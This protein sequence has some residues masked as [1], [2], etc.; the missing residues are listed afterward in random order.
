MRKLCLC[1]LVIALFSLSAAGQTNCP[2]PTVPSI[3]SSAIPAD[4]CVPANFAGN[5]IAFFDDY[6]WR[7]FVA[8]VWPALSG[9]RGTPDPNQTVNGSGPRVFETYKSLYE[10]FHVDGSA[11]SAWNSFDPPADNP[12]NVQAGFND[13][14]LASFSKFA[15]VG[16]AGFGTLVGPLI[17]QNK[18]YVR[19]MTGFDQTE[20][21]QILNSKL[22]LR[23]NLTSSITLPTG[24][25]DVKS[26]WMEMTNVA[27]PERYYTRTAWVMD[28]GTGKCSPQT[29][30]LVGL[31]I[32]QKTPSR[33][34]WIWSSFEQ[35][36]NVP[37]MQSGA[38][39]SN[40]NDGS[41]TPMP[42][43]N[44]YSVEP[45]PIPPPKPY[46]V[47]R[48]KPIHSST[49]A[50]NKAYQK[51]LAGTP[52]QNYQLV[53]TQWPLVPNDPTTFATPQNTFPGNGATTA[54]ANT[55]METFDQSTIFTGCMAC[56]AATQT[57]TDLVWA[58]KDHAFPSNIPGLVMADAQFRQLQSLLARSKIAPADAKA[59]AIPKK[60]KKQ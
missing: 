40:F 35:I 48:I 36:D 45:L 43:Q 13:M 27:H 22:Y 28:P 5:P 23:A 55:T 11:P 51:L 4:V 57:A 3:S 44:P 29:V 34:Q 7:A 6:S 53:M 60:T 54:F 1:L 46:N 52:F 19:F 31:H 15:N 12:C 42:T 9:Q 56:H 2:N 18:T 38:S 17:A 25:L 41:G 26:S 47:S 20:F 50:T 59:A 39:G 16:Q 14:I 30:G 33:P 49:Q 21:N 8:L 37:P 10:T 32:V 58:L 24:S